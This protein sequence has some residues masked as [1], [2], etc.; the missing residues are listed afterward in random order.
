MV[1][2]LD[3]FYQEQSIPQLIK[4]FHYKNKHQVPKL[5]KIV[6]NRGLGDASQNA[7]VLES[8]SKELSIITGQQGVVTRSKKAIASFKLREKMPVGLVVTLRGDKMYAFLDRLI[9]LAL[10]RIRDFQGVSRKSFDGR[11]NYS[12][13]L[14]E[15][16][17]FPEIDYDKIDQIRGMDV[18]IVTTAKTDKEAMAL[19]K[20]FGM[21]FKN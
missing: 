16:L 19:F 5:D 6:I 11:G 18:S 14:E 8:C 20:T 13:G 1:Q 4:E 9:N 15:Q 17:M 12:L 2:R 21:P 10:P 3:S 7:K